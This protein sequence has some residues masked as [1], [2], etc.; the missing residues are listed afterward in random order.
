MGIEHGSVS[1]THGPPHHGSLLLSIEQGRVSLL[2][3]G[4]SLT[5]EPSGIE[6]GSVPPQLRILHG[7]VPLLVGLQHGSVSLPLS[8]QLEASLP[9]GLQVDGLLLLG[10]EHGGVS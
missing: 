2:L 9:Q 8:F 3:R 4:V 1:L 5:L 7:G 6:H 10:L